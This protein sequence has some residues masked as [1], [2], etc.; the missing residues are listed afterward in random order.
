MKYRALSPFIMGPFTDPLSLS[1]GSV[2]STEDFAK[3]PYLTHALKQGYLEE[4]PEPKV[5]TWHDHL[6]EDD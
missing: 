6:M 1:K 3:Y 4:I 2:V 5:L